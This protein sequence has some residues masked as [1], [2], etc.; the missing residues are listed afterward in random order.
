MP[1]IQYFY[2]G[3]VERLP[4]NAVMW[5]LDDWTDNN[6]KTNDYDPG[7]LDGKKLKL[8]ALQRE[9]RLL[10]FKT[11]KNWIYQVGDSRLIVYKPFSKCAGVV[12]M[13]LSLTSGLR[14]P[15][16]VPMETYAK[17]FIDK[18]DPQWLKDNDFVL[19]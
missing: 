12:P 8:I 15:K 3:I 5:K 16:S 4:E 19:S 18:I 10:I 9:R 1:T 13:G 14:H 7:V 11:T 2:M 17:L 6:P